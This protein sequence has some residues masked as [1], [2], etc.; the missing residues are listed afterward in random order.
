VPVNVR[1]LD[2]VPAWP[3]D[4]AQTFLVDEF[5]AGTSLD[6]KGRVA[7]QPF[8]PLPPPV[9]GALEDEAGRL[10]AFLAD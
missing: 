9:R 5:V 6:E 3:S 7:L 2:T 8:A 10:E 4:V 1:G